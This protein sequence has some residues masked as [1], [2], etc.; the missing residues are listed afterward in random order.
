[1]KI[2]KVLLVDDEYLALNLLEQF[3]GQLTDLEVV[4]RCKSAIQ[5]LDI[6][7]NT[8]VDI[9]FLDIQMPVLSGVNMLKTLQR[10]PATIFTTAYSEHAVEAFNLNAVDYLLKP[11][12]FERFL[13]SVN[14]AKDFLPK[15]A[16]QIPPSVLGQNAAT[17]TVPKDYIVAKVDGKIEKIFFKD[18]IVIEGMRE[19]VKFVC[20][21]R[22]YITLES[23][24][25][26][27][28]A[29][30]NTDFLRVHKSFIVAKKR[31]QSLDGNQL[32]IDKLKIPISRE[33]KEEIVKE[34]FG[35]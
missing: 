25:N 29:L 2:Y 13:Q 15:N 16:E 34:I 5:A 24:K 7:N 18:I 19:Y 8:P 10:S 32:A 12:S 14:K 28:D 27:E 26:L 23:M 21:H 30:P 1:M 22:N 3:I 31:V 20:S 33:R 35:F 11:F 9:L 4:G 17:E 6:L